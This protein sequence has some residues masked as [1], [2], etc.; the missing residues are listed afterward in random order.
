M[1]DVV[2]KL[3]WRNEEAWVR[4]SQQEGCVVPPSVGLPGDV[5]VLVFVWEV[6]IQGVL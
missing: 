5:R 6:Y 4:L 1:S 3:H 2:P